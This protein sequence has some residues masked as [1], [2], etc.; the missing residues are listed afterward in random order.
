MVVSNVSKRKGTG[1]LVVKFY[2][3]HFDNIL[4]LFRQE[5]PFGLACVQSVD[6]ALATEPAR[7]TEERG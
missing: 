7:S 1:K 6:S 3:D 5:R 4:R 2:F